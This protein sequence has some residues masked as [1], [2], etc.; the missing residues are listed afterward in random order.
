MRDSLGTRGNTVSEPLRCGIGWPA[1]SQR[2]SPPLGSSRTVRTAPEPAARRWPRPQ[3]PVPTPSAPLQ[4]PA[5]GK[6][7]HRERHIRKM[8]HH[9]A[10]TRHGSQCGIARIRPRL[11][12]HSA[13]RSSVGNAGSPGTADRKATETPRAQ[14]ESRPAC[15]SQTVRT[16]PLERPSSR[17]SAKNALSVTPSREPCTVKSVSLTRRRK[18]DRRRRGRT[19][20]RSRQDHRRPGSRDGPL[21]PTGRF[22]HTWQ[23]S[24]RSTRSAK[25]PNDPR[26]DYAVRQAA[27]R[28]RAQSPNVSGDGSPSPGPSWSQRWREC[29]GRSFRGSPREVCCSHTGTAQSSRHYR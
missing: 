3:C 24:M 13:F 4:R 20:W 14:T 29:R 17:T 16:T 8:Q 27:G 18:R 5:S 9:L 11:T 2:P 21:S 25:R 6:G 23:G 26:W 7:P 12:A 10:A 28:E 1:I 22:D 19:G 15:R